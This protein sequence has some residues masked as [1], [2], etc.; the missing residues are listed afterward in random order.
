M[1]QKM[2]YFNDSKYDERRAYKVTSAIGYA[3]T[4]IFTNISKNTQIRNKWPNQCQPSNLHSSRWRGHPLHVISCRTVEGQEIES[5][6]ITGGI[7]RAVEWS[8]GCCYLIFFKFKNFSG[9]VLCSLGLNLNV[10]VKWHPRYPHLR[11]S[12]KVHVVNNELEGAVQTVCTRKD[13]SPCCLWSEK[14]HIQHCLCS[15][16]KQTPFLLIVGQQT[17]KQDLHLRCRL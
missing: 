3:K 4:P 5:S 15:G 7:F 12:P 6:N 17:P 1:K 11:P 16:T 13:I 14:V 9:E 8:S 2:H 10:K